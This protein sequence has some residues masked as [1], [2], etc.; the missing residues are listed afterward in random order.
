M[1]LI[2]ILILW[3]INIRCILVLHFKQKLLDEEYIWLSTHINLIINKTSSMKTF[4]FFKRLDSLPNTIIMVLEIW[5]PIKNYEK[6]LKSYKEI[7][8]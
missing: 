7:Y 3:V 8:L 4:I 1:I 2:L 6:N 5:K